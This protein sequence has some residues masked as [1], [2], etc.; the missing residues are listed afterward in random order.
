MP[1]DAQQPQPRE[2][3]TAVKVL[4]GMLRDS[5]TANP[6]LMKY[7]EKV[8]REFDHR[9]SWLLYVHLS[10][11]LSNQGLEFRS[12]LMELVERGEV[13]NQFVRLLREWGWQLELDGAQRRGRV[14]ELYLA[15]LF[16]SIRDVRIP[17][18][19]VHEE[20][21]HPN[22]V[23]M[24][25]V[26]AMA[27]VRKAKRIFEFGTYRGQTT[28]GLASIAEDVTVWTLNLPP[29][30]S[31]RYSEYIG[32]FIKTSPCRSRIQQLYADSCAFDTTPYRDSMDF[33]FV[34]ADHSY[35]AVENDT[36]K[37]LQMLRKGG[38]IVWHDYAAKSPGVYKF[39]EEFSRERS[40]F[41]IKDTCLIVYLDGID[42]EKFE[43]SEIES[44]LEE[45]ERGHHFV[46]QY[47]D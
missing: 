42:A 12:Q 36:E 30:S 15:E 46:E 14:R 38:A 21:H 3:D 39:I 24:L 23:D 7:I 34:D 8:F 11:W 44:S 47:P 22:K 31:D 45:E 29:E 6:D 26:C 1:T 41:R 27:A 4:G 28:C 25:Y 9:E 33:V 37:A 32:Q 16:P 17:V 20:S 18:G 2:V 40:V 43:K 35:P 13:A 10:R 5:L 19:V